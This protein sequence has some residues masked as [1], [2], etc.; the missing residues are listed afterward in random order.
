M[1]TQKGINRRILREKRIP[2][3]TATM[4]YG[5]VKS[6]EKKDMM[7]GTNPLGLRWLAGDDDSGGSVGGDIGEVI[8]ECP[9]GG[10]GKTLEKSRWSEEEKGVK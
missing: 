6:A 2:L 4:E 9:K 7:L 3:Q 8:I 1:I 5:Q 10:A